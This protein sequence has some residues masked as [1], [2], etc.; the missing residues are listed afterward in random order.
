MILS[1]TSSPSNEAKSLH[2]S[3]SELSLPVTSCK[4][5]WWHCSLCLASGLQSYGQCWVLQI[6]WALLEVIHEILPGCAILHKAFRLCPS[7]LDQA[8]QQSFIYLSGD[9]MARW[10]CRAGNRRDSKQTWLVRFMPEV[11]S[12]R[13]RVIQGWVLLGA[14]VKRRLHPRDT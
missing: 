14:N 1:I 11:S 4:L 2:K 5:R 7:N 10:S 12:W 6:R 9:H 13:S 8:P 3:N